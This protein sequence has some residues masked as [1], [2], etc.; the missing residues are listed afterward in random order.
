MS[1]ISYQFVQVDINMT[2][3][4]QNV[5]NSFY[6]APDFDTP[7]PD[8]SA[9]AQNA[10]QSIIDSIV[11]D[12]SFTRPTLE[13]WY[14]LMPTN[15]TFVSVDGKLKYNNAFDIVVY[16]RASGAAGGRSIG[17]EFMPPNITASFYA[18]SRRY[19]QRGAKVGLSGMYESDQ[20]NG[21]LLSGAGTFKA[22]AL[23]VMTAMYADTGL[24]ISAGSTTS[25]LRPVVI[26]RIQTGTP[27]NRVYR[28]PYLG[29]DIPDA[30][31]ITPW[32]A[33]VNVGSQNTR[34]LPVR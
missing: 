13:P 17:S 6:Y 24:W 30:T 8:D 15:C 33:P 27:P 14:D 11:D 34:K 18:P 4:G 23:P 32:Q 5:I 7:L 25:N 20:Q 12:V 22:L 3:L 10:L 2:F 9:G 31:E 21:L 29:G 28:M 26:P 19:R 1:V 16:S